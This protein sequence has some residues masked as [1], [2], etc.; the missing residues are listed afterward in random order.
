VKI[1]K[2]IIFIFLFIVILIGVSF[3]I[4]WFIFKNQMTPLTKVA[5]KPLLSYTFQN[6]KKTVFPNNP[7]TFGAI[8][9]Q[10]ADYISQMFYFS[11]PNTPGSKIYKKVSGL[12][13]IPKN[14][15]NYPVIIMFRGFVPDSIYN[16]GVGSQPMADILAKNGYITL[17]P[18]FLGYA[19]SEN[20]SRDPFEN[21][22]QT[23]TTALTLLSS[24]STLT[25]GL[26]ASY[27][28]TTADLKK[29]G[30]WGHSNGGA[31][32]LSVLEISGV[33]YPTVLWAPVS[34]SFPYSILYYTNESD[35]Q[36]KALR[37]TLASF[38]INYD[39]NLFSLTNFYSWIK[40]PL[41]I[42][43]GLADQEVPYWWSENLVST[44][45]KVNKT[46]T[47]LTYPDADHNM[48]PNE[49]TNVSIDTLNFYNQEFNIK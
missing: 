34:T 26:S 38:E 31:I 14:S 39:T 13:N 37:K 43:Q 1:H 32:A 35:D 25:Q 21:R 27:S 7:I 8:K 44:L 28:A 11:V 6:L 47:Y 16:P 46:I 42:N 18:D 9:S 41:E 15:G 48:L 5:P 33:T 4:S 20:P 22:F 45:K 23:N 40:A 30:I 17:A 12:A 36:G 49:W 29:V 3:V 2:I 19:E 24:L 10:N